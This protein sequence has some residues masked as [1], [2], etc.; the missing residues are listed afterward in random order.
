MAPRTCGILN[1]RGGHDHGG[2]SLEGSA[3]ESRSFNQA[4][5]LKLGAPR[6]MV[7]RTGLYSRLSRMAC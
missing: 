2:I 6:V 7:Q 5:R 4:H 3:T 1:E